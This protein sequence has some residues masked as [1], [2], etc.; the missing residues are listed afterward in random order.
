MKRLR[1]I[2]PFVLSLLIIYTG[3]GVAICHCLTCDM[4][5]ASCS[6][7]CDSCCDEPVADVPASCEDEACAVD[8]YKVNLMK[9]GNS[10]SVSTPSFDLFCKLLPASRVAISCGAVRE[11]AYIV[12]PNPGSSRHYLALYSLLLI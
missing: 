11:V 3:V 1:Y 2:L 12:P 4:A 9:Q 5:C 6:T 10:L 8:V 7:S